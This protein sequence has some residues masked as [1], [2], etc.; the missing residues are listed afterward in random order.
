MQSGLGQRKG[1]QKSW[2][3]VRSCATIVTRR[4]HVLKALPKN[5]VRMPCVIITDANVM[6][7]LLTYEMTNVDEE[8]RVYVIN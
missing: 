6:Y 3:S 7:A 5:T 8:Q 2:L 1:D 4:R